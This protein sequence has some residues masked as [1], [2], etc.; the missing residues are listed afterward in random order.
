MLVTSQPRIRKDWVPVGKHQVQDYYVSRPCVASCADSGYWGSV[1]DP[2]GIVRDRLSEPER[3]RYVGDMAEEL[4]FLRTLTPGNIID[5]GCG[6]GWLLDA[7]GSAWKRLGMDI[8]PEAQAEMER[9]GII[10]VP[11]LEMVKDQWADVVVAHHVIEHMADPLAEIGHMRAILKPGGWLVL[12]T[13]DFGSPCAVRFG[14]NYRMLHDPTHVSLF[15][16]ESMHRFLRDNGF[17]IHDVKFPFPSRYATPDNFARWNDTSKVSP[18]W[19]GNWMTY[20]AR[21]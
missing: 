7:I 10:S 16:L 20:Y 19:P 4:A 6:P 15:T 2:D 3:L 14:D 18:P 1:V 13:P 21:R 9:L 12:G 5:I 8:A 11:E 17:T